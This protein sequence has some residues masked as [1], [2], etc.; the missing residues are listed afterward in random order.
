MEIKKN[1]V[2]LSI[3]IHYANQDQKVL[4]I[5]V[6]I[7]YQGE[8][9]RTYSFEWYKQT[10][11]WKIHF[12]IMASV[13]K[14]KLTISPS[15]SLS[16]P[17]VS[18]PPGVQA[19]G[20]AG[21]ALRGHLV[22]WFHRW[23][24]HRLLA[25]KGRHVRRCLGCSAVPLQVCLNHNSTEITKEI[26]TSYLAHLLSLGNFVHLNVGWLDLKCSSWTGVHMRWI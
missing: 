3:W 9:Q 25:D 7:N 4:C 2:R 21:N 15:P 8:G 24:G 20:D 1:L 12:E 18:A 6:N 19:E 17:R 13:R 23:P 22:S 16:C 10:V 5:F 26:I 14:V 11:N